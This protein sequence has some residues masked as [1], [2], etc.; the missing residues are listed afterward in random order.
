MTPSIQFYPSSS[1]YVEAVPLSPSQGH[2]LSPLF[3]PY[4]L[5]GISFREFVQYNPQ[6]PDHPG[7]LEY[8]MQGTE[9][10]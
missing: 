3:N 2:H 5:M 10:V 8:R 6:H 1:R 9:D 4:S 7:G